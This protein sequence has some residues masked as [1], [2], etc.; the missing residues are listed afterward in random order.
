MTANQFD[1]VIVGAGSAGCVLAERLSRDPSV[2]VALLEAGGDDRNLLVEAPLMMGQAIASKTLDWHHYTAPQKHLNDRRLFWPR[3]KVLGGSSSINAMHYIRGAA[4]NYDE[5]RDTYGADGWGWDQVLPAFKQVEGRVG[6]P[7]DWHGAEGPLSVQDIAPLNPLT[8]AFFEACAANGI[9]RIDDM[10]GADQFGCAPYHVTQR[11]N[12]RCSA[13][14]AFL[15][16]ALSRSNLT[17]ITHALASRVLLEGT[18]ATGV[19]YRKGRH[20]ETATARR[21][22]ILSGGAINTPQL[23]QLSGI[24]DASWLRDA[25]VN[26]VVDLPGVGRNLQDHLDVLGQITTASTTSL[27]ISSKTAASWIGAVIN[28]L[29]DK[30]GLLST[31]PVQGGAFF[32]SS[33][34]DEMAD[35]LPDLQFAFIPAKVAPHGAKLPFGH[36]ASLHV[37]QLYPKSRGELRITS[38]DPATHPHI[39]PNYLSEPQ[40]L[41]VMLDGMEMARKVLNH[42]AFDFDRKAEV[43]PDAAYRT[44]AQ[45]ADDLK[46]RAETLYHPV[47]TCRMGKGELAVVDPALK[48]YGTQGL[49]VVDASV[50]PRLIGG[51]TNAPTMMIATRAADIILSGQE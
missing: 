24:G 29:A 23:L 38:S 32:R 39:D 12:K 44:R 4:Q 33:L 30:P 36:G 35:G 7:C 13:A 34:A 45:L 21:E 41:E 43:W 19:E 31:N 40:D 17:V 16:P 46:A 48:V 5:W 15:R 27:G 37:C 10:N 26:P 50:M 47:G 2:S 3:G 42:A 9:G 28:F 18:R 25:G 22:V 49:R 6:D 11:G 14:V 20:T 51:N 1:Y 8:E